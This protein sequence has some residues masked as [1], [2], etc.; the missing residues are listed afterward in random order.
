[1]KKTS[2]ANRKGINV[3][4][5]PQFISKIKALAKEMTKSSESK[6]SQADVI[7]TAIYMIEKEKISKLI[8]MYVKSLV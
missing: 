5:R 2:I 3:K 8:K 1:M 4:L 6:F 7:E